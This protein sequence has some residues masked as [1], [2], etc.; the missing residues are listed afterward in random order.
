MIFYNNLLVWI[1]YANVLRNNSFRCN[2]LNDDQKIIVRNIVNKQ[3]T[4]KYE[5]LFY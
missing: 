3:P 1:E 5:L 4:E 2:F